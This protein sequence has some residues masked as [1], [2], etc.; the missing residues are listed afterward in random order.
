MYRTLGLMHG[1]FSP[2]VI[3]TKQIYSSKIPDR[4]ES[5]EQISQIPERFC[6]KK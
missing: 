4:L 2:R 1:T 3:F 6:E 5:E